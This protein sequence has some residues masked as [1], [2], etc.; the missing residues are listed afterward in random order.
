MLQLNGS[1]ITD[2][3]C[4]V[5]LLICYPPPYWLNGQ[6]VPGSNLP[7]NHIAR[8]KEKFLFTLQKQARNG[9]GG[10]PAPP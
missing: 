1:G 4:F 5:N 9:G 8:L 7:I 6:C 10:T 2:K 3:K